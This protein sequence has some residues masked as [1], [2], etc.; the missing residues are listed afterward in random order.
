[1][2]LPLRPPVYAP[3]PGKKA[4][5]KTFHADPAK[6][7]E[8]VPSGVALT[9]SEL[10]RQYVTWRMAWPMRNEKRDIVPLKSD[11]LDERGIPLD[12]HQVPAVGAVLH[13]G[14]R[15]R[16]KRLVELEKRVYAEME[17]LATLVAKQGP[18]ERLLK[19][20][21]MSQA[22]AMNPRAAAPTLELSTVLYRYQGKR[23]TE[24]QNIWTPEEY[25]VPVY[26]M[27][28]ILGETEAQKLLQIGRYED[29]QW[30]CIREGR[31]CA[32]LLELLQRAAWW[33]QEADILDDKSV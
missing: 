3:K 30:I 11:K 5:D 32:H 23:S 1:V 17:S 2:H 27:V 12:L 10:F 24:Q 21:G 28:D 15:S 16:T 31:V 22:I 7:V 25:R 18:V 6:A 9:V 29:Y 8:H 26:N 14:G 19:D 33:N 4:K 13:F 20:V